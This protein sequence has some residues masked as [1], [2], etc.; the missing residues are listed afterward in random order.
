MRPHWEIPGALFR[1]A[2]ERADAEGVRLQ[3]V[4]RRLLAL[5]ADGALDP[6]EKDPVG[7][8]AGRR[9]AIARSA[10]LTPERR[11]EIAQRAVQTRWER[12]RKA[13]P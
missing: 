10:S 7:A 12:H 5:Y 6:S 11:R 2:T 1:R 13:N 3:D 9:G 4:V 8:A